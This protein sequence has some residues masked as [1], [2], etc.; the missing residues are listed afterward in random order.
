MFT[1]I[2]IPHLHMA[3]LISGAGGRGGRCRDGRDQ[4]RPAQP[5]VVAK[6]A[7]GT[8]CVWWCWV[9][10]WQSNC[11][12]QII[13]GLFQNH[14]SHTFP[15]THIYKNVGSSIVNVY[16]WHK[17]MFLL[18]AHVLCDFLSGRLG[19]T[20]QPLDNGPR[21]SRRDAQVRRTRRQ[22]ADRLGNMA[23]LMVE[24]KRM[25]AAEKLVAEVMLAHSAPH[26][27]WG[28][29]DGRRRMGSFIASSIRG[30]NLF[31]CF[32]F[33]WVAPTKRIKNKNAESALKEYVLPLVNY[34][35]GRTSALD[36]PTHSLYLSLLGA[37]HIPPVD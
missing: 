14:E 36:C 6:A 19:P 9:G 28:G 17:I 29:Q 30:P 1:L 12:H 16:S 7:A 25:D 26:S 33:I 31:V 32:L 21:E 34:S 24:Q 23:A 13:D 2:I 27:P 20:S 3:A 11:S 15:R 35:R 18:S 8:Q 5:V 10:R 37:P 22:L 4:H